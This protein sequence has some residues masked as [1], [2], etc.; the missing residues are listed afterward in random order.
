MTRLTRLML[1]ALAPLLVVGAA[2]AA[3]R[4]TGPAV[5]PAEDVV[6]WDTYRQERLIALMSAISLEPRLDG[7]LDPLFE[8]PEPVPATSRRLGF[9]WPVGDVGEVSSGFG[10]RRDPMAPARAHFHHGVDIRCGYGDAIRA[11][12]DGTVSGIG[13]SRVF[14]RWVTV[15][16]PYGFITFYGHLAAATVPEGKRVERGDRIG[17]CGSTGRSTG[18]HLHFEVRHADGRYDPFAFLR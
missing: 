17:T 2:G 3:S 18:P 12:N 4:A 7:E 15:E 9:A 11:S 6:W 8:A 13:Y 10:Y 5:V 16:H 1:L 14:G